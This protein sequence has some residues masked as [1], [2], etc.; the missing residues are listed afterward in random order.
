MGCTPNK[1]KPKPKKKKKNPT[2]PGR[3]M[4]A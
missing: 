3:R 4:R 1:P 2:K